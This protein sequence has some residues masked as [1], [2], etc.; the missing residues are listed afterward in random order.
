MERRGKSKSNSAGPT[1]KLYHTVAANEDRRCAHAHARENTRESDKTTFG[2]GDRFPDHQWSKMTPT[3][4]KVSVHTD[5]INCEKS[6]STNFVLHDTPTAG[7]VI[8]FQDLSGPKW[9]QLQ[10]K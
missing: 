1:C 3:A 7:K 5:N 4:G 2:L 8:G 9:L 6:C 10:G